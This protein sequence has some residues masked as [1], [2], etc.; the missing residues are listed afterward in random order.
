MLKP[1]QID[2]L[3]NKVYQLLWDMGMIVEHDQV[4]KIMLEKGCTQLPNGRIRIPR[5]L[6]DEVVKYQV[7]SK[8]EDADDQSL[9]HWFGP[10][11]AWTHF[12]C[13]KRQKPEYKKKI[14]KVFQMSVFGSGPNKFYDYPSR[15]SVA[16]NTQN[17]VEMLKLVGATPE[18]GYI[19]PWYRCDGHPRLERLE[20][21]ILGLKHAPDK[22]AGVEPMY[23]DEIKYI[24]E[25]G[26]IMGVPAADNV[27]YLSGSVAINRPLVLDYRNADQLLERHRRGVRRY[28]VANMPTFGLTT[29]AT[30]AAAI[31][32]TAADL[33][34]GMAAVY[35]VAETPE[36]MARTICNTID[37]RNAACTVAAPEGTML[38]IAVKELFDARFGGHL[39]SEPFFAVSAKIPGL[40]AVYENFYGA[41]RYSKLTGVPTLY[42][43]LG[44]VGYMGTGSPTQ[45][46]LDMHIRKSQAATKDSI[47]VND[48]TLA[49]GEIL[50]VLGAG[51]DIFLSREHTVRHYRDI[52]TS[53]LFL[54]EQPSPDGW[55]GDEKGLLDQCDQE[56]REN[57]KRWTPPSIPKE[58]LAALDG[59]L[60]R[61]AKEFGA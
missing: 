37:M 2:I 42:P 13:Y 36:L 53:P 46:M 50:E 39:W 45:A 8:A 25:I 52:W 58:K 56:W 59:V 31:V 33:V 23:H 12:I 9:F 49:Y 30:M 28:R 1:D 19:A 16:A 54:N 7:P 21:L 20:A 48:E 29:P 57:V 47:E 18:F 3:A 17:Y 32:M 55:H 4:T 41:Y 24:K 40:Q 38:N 26:E 14:G 34:G 60:T 6:I 35:A 15:Q 44:N 61:A 43:G 10:G 27:P 51:E 22:V 11:V 5:S